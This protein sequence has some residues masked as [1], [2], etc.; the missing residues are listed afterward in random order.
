MRSRQGEKEEFMRCLRILL[1]G[2]LLLLA[3]HSS[4]EGASSDKQWEQ[5]VA[6]AK[7]EGK[8]VVYGG[9]GLDRRRIYKDHFEAAF[10]DI[11][12][13]YEG[14][15]GRQSS[16]RLLAEYRARKH[17]VDVRLGAAGTIYEILGGKGAFQPVRPALLLPEV[18][19]ESKWFEGKLWFTDN[20]GEYVLTYSLAVSTMVAVNNRLVNPKEITSYRDLLNPKWRGK[21][22]S[23]DIRQSGPGSGNSRYLYVN[24]SLGPEFLR[25]LYSMDVTLSRNQSQM[26]DWLARGRFAI[27]LF[28]NL[29]EI[30]R[31]R[32]VGLPVE[33]VNPQRMK[34][35]YPVTAGFNSLLLM[36]QSPHPNAARVYVNWLLSRS[37]QTVFE[38]VLETPSLRR[39]TPSK[40][41]LRQFLVPQEGTDYMVVSLEKHRP[42]YKKGIQ[43]L[44]K[45][46]L[47]GR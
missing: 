22:V 34:E 37:G 28:P 45:R 32:E 27:F 10:P 39:D 15:G 38:K 20:K 21:I 35:G 36:N 19:D 12:V 44:L 46:V 47:R 7:Q 1:G 4:S 9:P 26:V 18:L 24:P 40:G 6:A 41:A 11:K 29:N 33:V 13:F 30:D 2:L 25:K 43:P 5:L 14:L 23:Q 3:L 8:V 16:S 17:I 31:A 42:I